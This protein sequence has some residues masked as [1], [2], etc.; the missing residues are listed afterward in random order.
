LL[1]ALTALS[2][3][4]QQ[5]ARTDA[6]PTAGE[7]RVWTIP[8]RVRGFTGRAELLAELEAAL[9]SGGP[10]VV[11]V[12]TAMGGIGKTTAAIE[13]AANVVTRPDN[14]RPR[15]HRHRPAREVPDAA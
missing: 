8:A 12:V 13:C 3:S 2:R 10:T 6:A 9:R 11:Q 15:S 1:Q 5:P 14:S 7:R 4:E